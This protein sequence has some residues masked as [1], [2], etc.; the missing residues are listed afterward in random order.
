VQHHSFTGD[1]PHFGLGKWGL[2]PF[3]DRWHNHTA[4]RILHSSAAIRE[5]FF[6][7]TAHEECGWNECADSAALP[8]RAL[9]EGRAVTGHPA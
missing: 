6:Y 3:S 1:C 9:H 5:V 4:R 7:T 2:S 8:P